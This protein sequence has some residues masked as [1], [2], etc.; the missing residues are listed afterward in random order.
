ARRRGHAR[1]MRRHECACGDCW[2]LR[3]RSVAMPS[4]FGTFGPSGAI[5]AYIY[6]QPPTGPAPRP[7]HLA[8]LNAAAV[9]D[10]DFAMDDLVRIGW[11]AGGPNF[12]TRGSKHLHTDA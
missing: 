1:C 10:V 2:A 7:A 12:G 6:C 3:S 11:Q 4:G 9:A 5:P 8:G